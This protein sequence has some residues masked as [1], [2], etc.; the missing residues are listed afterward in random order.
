[1]EIGLRKKFQLGDRVQLIADMRRMQTQPTL[2][3]SSVDLRIIEQCAKK[4][5]KRYDK[6]ICQSILTPSLGQWTSLSPTPSPSEGWS[7]LASASVCLWHLKI[8]GAPPVQSFPSFRTHWL[9][10]RTVNAVRRGLFGLWCWMDRCQDACG[11]RY[12]SSANTLKVPSEKELNFFSYADRPNH[13]L[14]LIC[15]G[16]FRLLVSIGYWVKK[17]I[18][19]HQKKP[20][21]HLAYE[22]LLFWTCAFKKMVCVLPQCCPQACSLKVEKRTW[23]AGMR[24]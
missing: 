6:F 7:T 10:F 9:G 16:T 18:N 24:L 1:M 22:L 11:R 8:Y 4:P 20:K 14:T 13:M 12:T 3:T 23:W 15:T 2:S 17:I 5:D 19:S 21:K